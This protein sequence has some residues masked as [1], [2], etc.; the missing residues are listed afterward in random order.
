LG[1]PD[2]DPN[3]ANKIIFDVDISIKRTYDFYI[4][5]HLEN[6]PALYKY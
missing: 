5:A 4:Y 2:G 6:M 1:I 3:D